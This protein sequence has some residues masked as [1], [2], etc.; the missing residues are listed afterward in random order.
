MGTNF[1][2]TTW[3]ISIAKT[4]SNVARH[5]L[6]RRIRGRVACAQSCILIVLESNC[7]AAEYSECRVHTTVKEASVHVHVDPTSLIGLD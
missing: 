7:S 6:C 2:S 5:T 1:T 4:G 3:R